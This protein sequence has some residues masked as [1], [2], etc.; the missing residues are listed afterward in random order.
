MRTPRRPNGS[1]VP[2]RRRSRWRGTRSSRARRRPRSRS[3]KRSPLP[4]SSCCRAGW[5]GWSRCAR[6]SAGGSAGTPRR[7]CWM[8]SPKW[9]S[10]ARRAPPSWQVGSEAAG[11]AGWSRRSAFARRAAR[12][13]IICTW[14]RAT[15]RDGVWG[16]REMTRILIAGVSTRVFAESAARAGYDVVAVDGFGDL[17]LRVQCREVVVARTANEEGRFSSKL[18]SRRARPL[19]CDA[20]AYVASFE[21]H[22]HAL[23]AL[24]RGR[25]LWGNPPA[26]VA[27]A[28][29][30]V[31]ALERLNPRAFPRTLPGPPAADEQRSVRWLVKPRASGGGTGIRIYQAGA[32]VPHGMYLQEWLPGVAGSGRF[33][34]PRRPPAPPGGS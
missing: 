3:R 14:C 15:R 6:R 18:A 7:G 4:R 30:P 23:R 31:R 34:P 29:D 12:C 28:R 26:V 22:P 2:R 25:A 10:R 27:R 21:N 19:A 17:D 33:S 20:V 1:V 13:S 5:R 32:P 24:A 16:C 9:R 11:T 8:G